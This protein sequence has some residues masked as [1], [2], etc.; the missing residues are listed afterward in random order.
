MFVMSLVSLNTASP[1]EL[2]LSDSPFT[3]DSPFPSSI[4][5]PE[6]KVKMYVARPEFL[7]CEGMREG[8]E[9]RGREAGRDDTMS[10]DYC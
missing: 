2:T 9:E 3:S 5:S 4:R 10:S 8:R 7:K 6:R 1:D